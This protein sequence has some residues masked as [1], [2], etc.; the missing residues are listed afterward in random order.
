MYP[1]VYFG[2]FHAVVHSEFE[3]M[4]PADDPILI[5][6]CANIGIGPIENRI[7]FMRIGESRSDKCLETPR[8]ICSFR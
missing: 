2:H 5:A 6:H 8:S 4:A 1:K 3:M 7:G